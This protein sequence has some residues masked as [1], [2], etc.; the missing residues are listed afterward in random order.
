M[1]KD[2]AEAVEAATRIVLWTETLGEGP[3][4]AWP[5]TCGDAV[6]VARALLALRAEVIEECAKAVESVRACP[7]SK[8]LPDPGLRP[9]DPCPVCGDLGTME[10]AG[11][12][13]NCQSPSYTIR[14]LSSRIRALTHTKG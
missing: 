7:F 11:K 10:A 5:T 12:A 6:T 14:Q 13:S 4:E 8:G 9:E 1:T 2:Q 3:P